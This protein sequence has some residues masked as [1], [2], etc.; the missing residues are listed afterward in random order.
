[1]IDDAECRAAALGIGA[2]RVLIA[3]GELNEE[4]YLFGRDDV[5]VFLLAAFAKNE[6]A[7]L[8]AAERAALSK[9]VIKMLSDCR[10][11]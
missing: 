1:V 5:P 10:R 4:A 9:Q 2:D 11:R 8:T 6:K 3:A 7:D